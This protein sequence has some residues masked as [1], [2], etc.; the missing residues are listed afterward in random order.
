MATLSPG[1]ESEQQPEEE[2]DSSNKEEEE[3]DALAAKKLDEDADASVI[4]PSAK[5]PLAP[6]A[7]ATREPEAPPVAATEE[8]FK[9]DRRLIGEE[10]A[11]SKSSKGLKGQGDGRR[12]L[13]GI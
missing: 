4:D 5:P 3:E 6:L 8:E 12:R 11:R 1:I 9:S 10:S 7:V 2:E 13:K